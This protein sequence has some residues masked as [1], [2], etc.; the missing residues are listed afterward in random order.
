MVAFAVRISA[1]FRR[2]MP[3]QVRTSLRFARILLLSVN[4]FPGSSIA[5]QC[6]HHAGRVSSSPWSLVSFIA[7]M[8][9]WLGWRTLTLN[10]TQHLTNVPHRRHCIWC[11]IL[12][13]DKWSDN[14]HPNMPFECER[15]DLTKYLSTTSNTPPYEDIHLVICY[16]NCCWSFQ[17][18]IITNL[19]S[20]RTPR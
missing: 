4:P 2:F 15:H 20:I 9:E 5:V 10:S 19:Y 16:L 11:Y 17:L 3:L 14:T 13:Y 1:A 8:S 12:L 7:T 6:F 18:L